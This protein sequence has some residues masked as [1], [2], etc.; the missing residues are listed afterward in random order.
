MGNQA[1]SAVRDYTGA[2]RGSYSYIDAEGKK[3]FTDYIADHN[4]FRVVSNNLP[5]APE[6]NLEAPVFNLEAPVFDLE[7]PVFDLVGPAPVEDTPE[8][9]AAKEEHF[10]AVAEAKAAHGERRKREVV[11][12]HHVT[13]YAYGSPYAHAYAH[14]APVGREATLTK[15]ILN[16]GH[17]E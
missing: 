5:V 9:K 3:V 1:H 2:V 14:P 12:A 17:A 8:V 6:A 11:A 4:G 15:T 16:P 7:A 10:A 13:P